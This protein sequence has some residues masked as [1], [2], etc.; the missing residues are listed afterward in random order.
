MSKIGFPKIL[1]LVSFINFSVD[2][3]M[4]PVPVMVNVWDTRVL[5]L[6]NILVYHHLLKNKLSLRTAPQP[7]IY[8]FA[9]I[10]HPMTILVF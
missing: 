6:V 3:A 9:T 5:E 2:S 4:S 8:Y 1:L 7:I 10:H